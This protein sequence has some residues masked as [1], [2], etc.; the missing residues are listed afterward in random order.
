VPD[1]ES[2]VEGDGEVELP[3]LVTPQNLINSQHEPPRNPD[4]AA[5]DRRPAVFAPADGS[6]PGS[7]GE[8]APAASV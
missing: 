7:E 5:L 1:T 8:E 2:G 3:D 6:S 4:T